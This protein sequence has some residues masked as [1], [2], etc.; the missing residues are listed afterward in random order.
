MYGVELFLLMCTIITFTTFVIFLIE[1]KKFRKLR[2]DTEKL[3]DEFINK[4]KR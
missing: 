3:M 1:W 4:Y 2:K